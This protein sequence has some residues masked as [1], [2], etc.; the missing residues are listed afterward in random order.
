LTHRP[1]VISEELLR[2]LM[3]HKHTLLKLLRYERRRLEN[4]ERRGLV[5]EYARE[6]GWIAL[7]D[8]TTGE[9]HEVR[10]S[11]CLPSVVQAAKTNAR[12]KKQER[13]E[14]RK[15]AIS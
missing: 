4:A 14:A 2:V 12:R 5:I 7:H 6:P 10:E 13:K 8:P 3:S 1:G 11:E 9:C 15:G